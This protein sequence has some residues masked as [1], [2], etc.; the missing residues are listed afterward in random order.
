MEEPELEIV[1]LYCVGTAR[2]ARIEELRRIYQRGDTCF[3]E[4]AA[5]RHLIKAGIELS[6]PDRQRLLQ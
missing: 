6:A 4:A 3:V 1:F 2:E 5:D